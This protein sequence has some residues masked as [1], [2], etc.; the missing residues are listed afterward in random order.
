MSAE[1]TQK[2]TETAKT[3]DK[4]IFRDFEALAREELYAEKLIKI[5]GYYLY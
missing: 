3:F 1:R 4:H 2:S 5:T